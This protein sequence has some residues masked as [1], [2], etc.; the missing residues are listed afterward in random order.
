MAKRRTHNR[1]HNPV[2]GITYSAI[3]GVLITAGV[4]GTKIVLTGGIL[5]LLT[6]PLT[7]IAGFLALIGFLVMQMALK[8]W[9]LSAVMPMITGISVL[10]SNV[11]GLF[12]FS[13][14]ISNQKWLAVLLILLGIMFMAAHAK[15]GK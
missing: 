11:L 4:F 1:R 6:N 8:E 3:S 15:S 13:E 9:H 5:E 12:F 10:T 14:I 2:L 7:Y